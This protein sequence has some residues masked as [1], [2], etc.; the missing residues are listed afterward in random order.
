MLLYWF[1]CWVSV[2]ILKFPTCTASPIDRSDVDSSLIPDNPNKA[3]NFLSTRQ[4]PNQYSTT[5]RE[6]L[7]PES[8][9]HSDGVFS[10]RR[11]QNKFSD[12]QLNYL[13]KR[14]F[15]GTLG[16]YNVHGRILRA[17]GLIVPT[18][19]AAASITEFFN[20]LFGMIELGGYAHYPE[21]NFRVLHLGNFEISFFCLNANIPWDFIQ[22]YVLDK[23]SAVK[24]GFTAEFFEW[25]TVVFGGA[26]YSVSVNMRLRKWT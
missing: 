9:W 4:A 11:R 21:S 6:T 3:A 12:D 23:V 16:Q 20:E 24:N 15:G 8:L 19:I 7:G 14:S 1:F 17:Y 22:D 5:A 10:K 2:C 18:Y 25:M 26:T 13:S